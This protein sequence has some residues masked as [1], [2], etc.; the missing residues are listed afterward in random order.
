MPAIVG[1]MPHTHC[2]SRFWVLVLDMA[3]VGGLSAVCHTLLV[4]G[5]GLTPYTAALFIM[6]PRGRCLNYM[7]TQ[8]MGLYANRGSCIY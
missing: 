3:I 7:S 1:A 2:H 4:G 6:P 8:S 5:R